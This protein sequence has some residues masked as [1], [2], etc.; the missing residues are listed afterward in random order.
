M[1]QKKG[2]EQFD[3]ASHHL[4]KSRGANQ[5]LIVFVSCLYYLISPSSQTY[6]MCGQQ[7]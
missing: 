1:L 6:M 2:L 5:G 3:K 4:K 7:D